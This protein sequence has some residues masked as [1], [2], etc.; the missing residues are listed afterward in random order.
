[1]NANKDM[2]I[3]MYTLYVNMRYMF[4]YSYM[5]IHINRSTNM[6]MHMA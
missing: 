2:E 6:I 1:M 4:M 3:N 5:Y